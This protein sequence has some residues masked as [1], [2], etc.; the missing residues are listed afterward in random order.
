MGLLPLKTCAIMAQKQG[1][2]RRIQETG[3]GEWG[4]KPR[5]RVTVKLL[6]GDKSEC[7]GRC[8][9]LLPKPGD[10]QTAGMQCH[11]VKRNLSFRGS[12]RCHC[13]GNPYSKR[14]RKRIAAPVCGLARN[15][16]ALNLMALR[17]DAMSFLRLRCPELGG[18][19]RFFAVVRKLMPRRTGS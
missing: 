9:A 1:M 14:Q 16:K 6:W 19:G 4:E 10:A 8:I 12:D 5:E 17:R 18:C 2:R 3:P 7:P 11:S 13:R 15:D